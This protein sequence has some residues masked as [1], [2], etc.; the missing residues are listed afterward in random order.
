MK[1]IRNFFGHLSFIFRPRYWVM[2]GYYDEHADQKL[3]RL[4]ETNDFEPVNA[5]DGDEVV[6]HVKLGDAY[7]WVSNF[8]YG[9]FTESRLSFNNEGY[10]I[11]SCD[12]T[13][14]LRPSRLTIHRL[15]KKL[16]KDLAKHSLR[17][18]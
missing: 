17:H 3:L 7:Y 12:N 14:C 1:K 18:A 5:F 4:A 15:H 11:F 8:P 6:Y 13:H 10:K 9:F 2:L 16:I